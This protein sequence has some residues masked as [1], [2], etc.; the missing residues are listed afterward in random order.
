MAGF[1][2]QVYAV[3]KKIP[4]GKVATYGQ[5]ASLLDTK[6]SRKVGWAL[7]ANSN[8][9]VP[10]HRVVNKDGRL[11]PNFA[12]DGWR[13]QKRRLLEEGIPFKG[14]DRVDLKKCKMEL[15]P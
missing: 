13:E 9:E 10:C 2:E 11:A 1:F 12:F 6:D 7:H 5:I 15:L 3:V 8:Q 4:E 14:E